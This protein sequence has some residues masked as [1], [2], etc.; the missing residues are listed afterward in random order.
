MTWEV[1]DT[2]SG[3]VLATYESYGAAQASIQ[4]YVMEHPELIEE[5]SILEVDTDGRV[6]HITSAAEA[7]ATLA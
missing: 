1:L 3:D 7:T 6:H 2:E 5:L 4:Q